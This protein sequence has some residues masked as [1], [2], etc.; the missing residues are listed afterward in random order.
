M[1]IRNRHNFRS[2]KF[3]KS[4]SE[5]GVNKAGWAEV[6]QENKKCNT[7]LIELMIFNFLLIL[8]HMEVK[9]SASQGHLVWVS[10]PWICFSLVSSSPCFFSGPS[11]Q[12][13]HCCILSVSSTRAVGCITWPTEVSQPLNPCDRSSLCL[14]YAWATWVNPLLA[15]CR[16]WADLCSSSM[17]GLEMEGVQVGR[18]TRTGF[19]LS[20]SLLV[21]CTAISLQWSSPW[22]WKS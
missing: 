8:L 18:K 5:V 9:K 6:H 7:W 1:S 12:P 3:R 10:G 14:D 17:W 2:Q 22:Q 15:G 11:R 16:R 21:M 19:S 13:H 4:I 20:S